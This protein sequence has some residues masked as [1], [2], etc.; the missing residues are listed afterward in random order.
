MPDI[1]KVREHSSTS[2]KIIHHETSADIVTVDNSN[3]S[4]IAGS[5][6]QDIINSIDESIKDVSKYVTAFTLT[7]K[8]IAKNFDVSDG[9]YTQ[10]IALEK[11]SEND[12]P[13]V[14]LVISNDINLVSDEM[15]AWG[16]IQRVTCGDGFIVVH[17][18]DEI[19]LVDINI[20]LKVI[21]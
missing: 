3:L 11:I 14:G 13:I 1:E 20:Q 7:T 21:H 5:N 15:E 19:P 9:H 4:T 17:C 2:D 10:K 12:N 6:V 16:C 18:Y 8:I